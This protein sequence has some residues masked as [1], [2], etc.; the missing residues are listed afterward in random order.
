MKMSRLQVRAS[1]TII[2]ALVLIASAGVVA[3]PAQAYQNS[4]LCIV[5]ST[6]QTALVRFYWGGQGSFRDRHAWISQNK[7]DCQTFSRAGGP[8]VAASLSIGDLARDARNRKI[9]D[10]P[11]SL[12]TWFVNN[13]AVGWPVIAARLQTTNSCSWDTY[14]S[15]CWYARLGQRQHRCVQENGYWLRPSREADSGN[16][17]QFRVQIYDGTADPA[18]FGC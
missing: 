10:D 8:D 11:R 6:S 4:Q 1:G 7:E 5:N 2:A 3:P 13:P 15:T 16:A 18:T 17:K 9:L 12:G 14:T